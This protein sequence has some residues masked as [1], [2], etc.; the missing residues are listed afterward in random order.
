MLS[1]ETFK[2]KKYFKSKRLRNTELEDPKA[3]RVVEQYLRVQI[4]TVKLKTVFKTV[5]ARHSYL[6]EH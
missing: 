3:L 2:F 1:S 4:I 5:T 6:T